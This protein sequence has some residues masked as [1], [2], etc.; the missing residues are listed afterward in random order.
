[1]QMLFLD[2]SGTAPNKNDVSKSPY[3]VLGGII[4]PEAQWKSLQRNLRQTKKEYNVDGEIKWRYFIYHPLAKRTTPTSHLDQNQLDNLRDDLYQIIARTKSFRLLAAVVDTKAYYQRHLSNDAED[5][6]HDAFEVICERFQYY[7]QDMGRA[8]T[9]TNIYGMIVIDERNQWQ[10]KQLD[11]FHY[12]LLNNH[13]AYRSNYN[14]LVEGL[15]I[16]ASHHSVGVQFADL[17]AGAV[18]R[19]VSKNDDRFYNK[20]KDNFRKSPEGDVNGYGIV[21]VPHRAIRI[22]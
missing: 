13:D 5:L 21:S 22:R 20:I 17:V 18:Y 8:T 3:F 12:Q 2:E 19:M 7:L 11:E 9:G 14:N 16:A 6:Y 4:V 15:F 10:N 1:M